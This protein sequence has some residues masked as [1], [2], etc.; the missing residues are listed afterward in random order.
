MIFPG[1]FGFS[2][3]HWSSLSFEEM[4]LN[5]LLRKNIFFLFVRDM[6][7][8]SVS[9]GGGTL[10]HPVSLAPGKIRVSLIHIPDFWAGHRLFLDLDTGQPSN[11]QAR[12]CSPST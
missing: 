6:V 2:V 1:V 9:R 8:A 3:F 10:S 4:N 5:I 11:T 12:Q 7:F